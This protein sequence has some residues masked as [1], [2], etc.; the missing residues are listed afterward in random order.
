MVGLPASKPPGS[1]GHLSPI[2]KWNAST[3]LKNC[4]QHSV[5]PT[6]VVKCRT[7]EKN[8]E[9]LFFTAVISFLSKWLEPQ[10]DALFCNLYLEGTKG[11]MTKSTQKLQH[12]RFGFFWCFLNK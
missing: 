7:S 4:T 12:A 11:K 10:S 1:W 3:L 6:A 5:F 9:F 8:I 2:Y